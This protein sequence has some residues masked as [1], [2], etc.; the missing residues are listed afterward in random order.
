Q[1]LEDPGVPILMRAQRAEAFWTDPHLSPPISF[2]E[3]LKAAGRQLDIGRVS[4]G[5]MY[6]S[7][8]YAF[9]RLEVALAATAPQELSNL[10]RSKFANFAV[11]P[12]S[13]RYMSAYNASDHFVLVDGSV[14]DSARILRLSAREAEPGEES[15]AASYLLLLELTQLGTLDQFA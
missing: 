13:A 7:E 1:A 11:R 14:A 15:I 8:D 6:T 4:A 10:I 5:R 3:D 12:P 2:V 9:E